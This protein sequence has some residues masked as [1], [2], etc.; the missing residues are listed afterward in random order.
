M[1]KITKFLKNISEEKGFDFFMCEKK[2]EIWVTGYKERVKFDLFVKPV[3]RH[4]ILII[5]EKPDERKVA[6]FSNKIE[7]HKR[8]KKIFSKEKEAI[9]ET[10]SV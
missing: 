8:L 6:L 10:V 3:K 7:A 4:Q 2:G 9:E 1:E 5:Y